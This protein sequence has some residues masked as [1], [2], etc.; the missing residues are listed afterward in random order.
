MRRLR[1]AAASAATPI[2]LCGG[3][4]V[5]EQPPPPQHG[6]HKCGDA[7][8]ASAEGAGARGGGGSIGQPQRRQ[9]LLQQ[10]RSFLLAVMS[11]AWAL[12]SCLLMPPCALAFQGPF[13]VPTATRMRCVLDGTALVGGSTGSGSTAISWLTS[14]PTHT[15]EQARVRHR[16]RQPFCP[17]PNTPRPRFRLTPAAQRP[18]R[19]PA[20]A[21]VQL[22]NP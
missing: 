13:V 14:H 20:P 17:P 19:R 15:P 6:G 18:R 12:V 8:P 11:A 16:P 1:E 5:P 21:D 22:R 3:G 9:Q 4:K 10:P 7:I 2:P